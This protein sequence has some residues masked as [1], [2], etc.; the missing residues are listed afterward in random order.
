LPRFQGENLQRNVELVDRVAELAAGLD[1]SP[2]QIALAWLLAQGP[3][4]VPIPGMETRDRLEHNLGA[5]EVELTSDHLRALELVIP[6]GAVGERY[7]P[8]FQQLS[9][10]DT[11]T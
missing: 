8:A 11:T 5:L 9:K 1:L 6:N 2:V 4:V 7:A 10:A 3:D